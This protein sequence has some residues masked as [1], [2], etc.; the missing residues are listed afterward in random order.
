MIS[1][2]KKQIRLDKAA[3]G[4]VNVAEEEDE[5]AQV[6]VDF[7]YLTTDSEDDDNY[8]NHHETNATTDCVNEAKALE[9]VSDGSESVSETSDDDGAHDDS[10]SAPQSDDLAPSVEEFLSSRPANDPFEPRTENESKV[11]E[12]DSR[13]RATPWNTRC[14]TTSSNDTEGAKASTAYLKDS[15]YL[16]VIAVLLALLVGA[17]LNPFPTVDGATTF[18]CT[19]PQWEHFAIHP[20]ALDMV[21]N[22]STFDTGPEQRPDLADA[23][24][25]D[26]M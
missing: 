7:G 20:Q 9:D 25:A 4:A 11:A 2:A 23:F 1:E 13:V 26:P 17:S 14:S 18:H 6:S 19:A 24:N 5:E 10:K 16:A 3:Q 22:S 8:E 12:S 21:T 15:I